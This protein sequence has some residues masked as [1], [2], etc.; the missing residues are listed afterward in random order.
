[1]RRACEGWRSGKGFASPCARDGR[2]ERAEGDPDG[3]VA[4]SGGEQ[5]RPRWLA[6]PA[7]GRLLAH[8]RADAH[9]QPDARL[10]LHAGGLFRRHLPGQGSEFLG[11]RPAE[12]GGNGRDR[13]IH[14]T[15]SPAPSRRA[16]ACPGAA[17]ARLLI[18]RCRHLPDGVDRRSLATADAPPS[19]GCGPGR[20]PVLSA[21]SAGDRRCRGGDRRRAVGDGRLDAAR[22]HDPRRCR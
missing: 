14:R 21:L 15:L 12:R 1:M 19:A 9:P 10:V 22:R 7:L 16:G 11:R 17:H 18:H 2:R 5:H 13:R 8:L 4:D 3:L 20:G 6:V